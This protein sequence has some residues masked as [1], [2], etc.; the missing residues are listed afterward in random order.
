MPHRDAIF[1]K[2]GHRD[3]IFLSVLAV[4]IGIVFGLFLWRETTGEDGRIVVIEVDGQEYGRYPLG[5]SRTIPI[6]NQAGKVTNVLSIREHRAEMTEADC[7]DGLCM[8]QPSIA[9]TGENI[10]CLPNRIVARVEGGASEDS[11]VSDE[12]APDAIAR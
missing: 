2:F 1:R 7:P 8:K 12:S 6:K 9:K 4:T 5:E 11:E 10:V 3:V